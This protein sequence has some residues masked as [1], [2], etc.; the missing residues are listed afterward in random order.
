[1]QCLSVHFP[2]SRQ[3]Y[4]RV[5][6]THQ[7]HRLCIEKHFLYKSSAFHG[8]ITPWAVAQSDSPR[9]TSGCASG[10]CRA[11]FKPQTEPGRANSYFYKISMIKSHSSGWE[12]EIEQRIL[13]KIAGVG[14]RIT[15]RAGVGRLV[16]LFH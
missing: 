16:R 1:M 14:H 3:Q 15:V 8:L 9:G 11:G 13:W 7:Q 6:K 5:D 4:P 12:I 2:K 10:E